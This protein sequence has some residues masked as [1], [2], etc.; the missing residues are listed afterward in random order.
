MTAKMKPISLHIDGKK[1]SYTPPNR[2]VGSLLGSGH[3]QPQKQIEQAVGYLWDKYGAPLPDDKSRI[4]QLSKN[5]DT[6]PAGVITF[7][8]IAHS[9]YLEGKG[10]PAGADAN[11]LDEEEEQ[12]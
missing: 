10:Q 5:F 3:G 8:L 4:T 11:G 6:T 9:G 7:A 2:L 1:T 12:G